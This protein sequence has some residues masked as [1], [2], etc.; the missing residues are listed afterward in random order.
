M[1]DPDYPQEISQDE[2]RLGF[3][4]LLIDG[5]GPVMGSVIHPIP[6]P[7]YACVL[8]SSD[9]LLK[10]YDIDGNVRYSHRRWGRY[11][12]HR[13]DWSPLASPY[14]DYRQF[15]EL[16]NAG[17]HPEMFSEKIEPASFTYTKVKPS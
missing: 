1:N 3:Q 7:V 6:V 15:F 10:I 4:H 11:G 12:G 5:I 17:T 8:S 9:I 14:V 2:A 13:N 16:F